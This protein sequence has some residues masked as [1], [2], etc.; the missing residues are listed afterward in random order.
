MKEKE[1]VENNKE[2]KKGSKKFHGIY[3]R[4]PPGAAWYD[5]NTTAGQLGYAKNTNVPYSFYST[6]QFST[7]N[8]RNRGTLK[9]SKGM[10]ER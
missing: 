2:K 4:F 10:I 5:S 8:N 1:K 9:P 6:A 7:L 3:D